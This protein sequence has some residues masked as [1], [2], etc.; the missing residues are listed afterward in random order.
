MAHR[1][2]QI[3]QP[4][5]P[6]AEPCSDSGWQE[7]SAREWRIELRQSVHA[8]VLSLAE[9]ALQ[10]LQAER[11]QSLNKDDFAALHSLHVRCTLPHY[12]SGHMTV[13]CL[14]AD[15]LV[16]AWAPVIDYDVCCW[17]SLPI[18]RLDVVFFRPQW[19]SKAPPRSAAHCPRGAERKE[20][21]SGSSA[22]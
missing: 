18:S 16:S 13:A 5:S 9:E 1:V 6:I 11:Q 19:R 15:L 7:R 20:S 12:P 22:V 21:A 4:Q 14:P 8:A 17:N 2:K 3:S 10:R